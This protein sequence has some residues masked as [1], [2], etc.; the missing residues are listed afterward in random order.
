MDK[1][2]D[3]KKGRFRIRNATAQ[4]ARL[5]QNWWNDGKV[6]AHAGFPNGLGIS[7]EDIAASLQK[8]NRFRRRL[9]IEYE[10]MPI[11]EMSYRTPE[12]E[13]AEIGIKI[14]NASQ[15]NKGFGTEYLKML[16]DYL[17]MKLNYNK[18]ILDTNLKNTR[19]QKVYERLGFR[20]VRTNI[21]SWKDQPGELQSS[22][23]YE[24]TFSEYKSLYC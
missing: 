8:D 3:V 15:Q 11:G 21:D 19:A 16:M 17:F 5:L 7:E 23:D 14:C 2:M 9:I 20:R 18:I 12:D 1:T 10:D 13:V 24:M 22:I 4:D 6:M